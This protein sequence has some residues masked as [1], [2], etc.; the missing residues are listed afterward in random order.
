MND[1]C[2]AYMK[3]ADSSRVHSKHNLKDVAARSVRRVG[4]CCM[5]YRWAVRYAPG[6]R[7]DTGGVHRHSGCTREATPLLCRVGVR[8]HQIRHCALGSARHPT[9]MCMTLPVVRAAPLGVHATPQRCP[10][11]RVDARGLRGWRCRESARPSAGTRGSFCQD[12]YAICILYFQD[13][14]VKRI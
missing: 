4:R 10:L 6:P 3:T 14:V 9:W 13:V 12:A 7:R 2:I 5:S 11:R 1:S 8:R